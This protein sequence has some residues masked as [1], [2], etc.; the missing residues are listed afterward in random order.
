MQV[1][2]HFTEAYQATMVSTINSLPTEPETL[3]IEDINVQ[4]IDNMF[5]VSPPTEIAVVEEEN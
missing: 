3:I 5:I 4:M 1:V 2:L